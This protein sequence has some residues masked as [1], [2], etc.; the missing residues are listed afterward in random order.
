MM[1]G[2][3]NIHVL[4]GGGAKNASAEAVRH[5]RENLPALMD[6]VALMATLHR[7]KFNAL[8][9]EGFTDEQALELC[10]SVF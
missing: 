6:H 2:K 9:A 3:D 1:S 8:K 4:T 7:A 5:L 10:R